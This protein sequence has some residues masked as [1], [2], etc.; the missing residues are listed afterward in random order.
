MDR[1]RRVL[2]DFPEL[3]KEWDWEKN[4]ALGL[5]PSR[6]S[7]GT[8]KKAYWCCAT[9]GNEWLGVISIRTGRGSGC[10]ICAR[11]IGGRKKTEGAIKKHGY[12]DDPILLS[13]Y[14]LEKNGNIPPE[15]LPKFVLTPVWWKCRDCSHEWKV[16]VK[17]RA[18]EHHGCPRCA[19]IK[20]GA[21]R[22]ETNAKRAS[23]ADR[24]D[25]M[26]YWDIQKNVQANIDPTKLGTG[27]YERVFW[28]CSVCGDS[29][30][31]QV[32][33]V[34]K[35][36]N[37]CQVC[38][39]RKTM[40][41]YNDFKTLYPEMA[42]EWDYENNGISPDQVRPGIN[43]KCYWR[44]PRGHSYTATLNHRTADKGTGCPQCSK[45]RQTSFPEQ[46]FYYY[47]KQ[48]FPDAINRAKGV[49]DGNL[50][51]DIYIPSI[52]TAIEYDGIAF[53]N[54]SKAV[55]REKKKYELCRKKRIKLF[56]IRE[57]KA[58]WK[59]DDYQCFYGDLCLY[60]NDN[61]KPS[62]LTQNICFILSELRSRAGFW[63][64]PLG[65]SVDVDRDYLEISRYLNDTTNS[66]AARRPD[67]A[68][69]WDYEKNGT[70]TP[71]GILVASDKKV[72]WKCKSC[73]YSWCCAVSHRTGKI[74]T[75]CPECGKVKGRNKQ[76]LNRLNQVGGLK[77]ERLRR[78]FD[79]QKNYPLT[80]DDITYGS[81]QPIWWLCPKC[82]YSWQAKVSN[83]SHGR[84]CACCSFRV[85]VP[86]K[87]D[88]ATI[89]PELMEEWDPTNEI[90]PSQE[91][92]TSKKKAKWICR[93]C[94]HHWSAAIYTRVRG[95]RCPACSRSKVKVGINDLASQCPKILSEWDYEKNEQIGLY[96]QRVCVASD[97]KAFWKCS[98]GHSYQATIS[99]RTRAGSGCQ[100]CYLMRIRH[101]DDE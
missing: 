12:I 85:L 64:V 36:K 6:I 29:W 72:W 42:K 90:D 80:P 43:K 89:H 99:S 48:L 100:A 33:D 52:F 20:R 66:L 63:P 34:A 23:V 4:S 1:E 84:G 28:H 54:G 13:E 10:P 8:G 7:A 61:L 47:V 55:E 44:C 26:K 93:V 59:K 57:K 96:P 94:G 73:G 22:K 62:Q 81:S 92:N 2:T 78:E 69:E 19:G 58:S 86:G 37:K 60:I 53:H 91:V 70:Y 46:A 97:K 65:I 21:K 88:L 31:A 18:I 25:L 76:R 24:P 3:M 9:C 45:G 98:K 32:K 56:R 79:P 87:N 40:P 30:Q 83:R 71:E 16:S 82:G 95:T 68:E 11:V 14:M 51:L 75:G 49:L 67:I 35:A 101:L 41:G 15:T 77:D 74:S 39:G 5:D 50:E 17:D 38:A 27:S